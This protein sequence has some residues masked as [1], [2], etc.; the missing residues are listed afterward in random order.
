MSIDNDKVIALSRRMVEM[1]GH[2]ADGYV[3]KAGQSKDLKLPLPV[4]QP[5][6]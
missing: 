5:K 6:K 2:A 4:R 3:L 1:I